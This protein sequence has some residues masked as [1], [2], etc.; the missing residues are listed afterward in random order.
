MATLGKSKKAPQK[1]W[2]P[3]FR[4]TETLP[5]TKVIRTGFL[6]NFVGI[7]VA[8]VC[9]T[10]YGF[11][12]FTL[13]GLAKSVRE[14]QAQV[15]GATS[16]DRKSLDLN[17]KFI[18]TAELVSE[19]IAF[20]QEPVKYHAFL[21]EIEQSVQSGM[22]L[23]EI[24]LQH[25]GAEPGESGLPP[26]NIQ[27]VGKVLENTLVTPAQVLSNFQSSINE[28]P[29]LSQK[30][31]EMEMVRFNRNNEFGYFDFTLLVKISVKKAPAS[32]Q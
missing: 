23:T 10:L 12:E 14:L 5:D 30:E 25:S 16:N 2:R 17:K 29:S 4:N 15:E 24:T 8:V 18:Q 28:L 31:K 27:L 1:L 32:E 3:D 26:F 19:V 13:Q 9:M 20:D 11:R 7:S 21:A 22:Q 6:L